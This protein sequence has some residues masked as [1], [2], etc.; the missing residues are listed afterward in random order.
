MIDDRHVKE[1]M[2]FSEAIQMIDFSTIPDA[3]VASVVA[4]V[5]NDISAAIYEAVLRLG[6]E[7]ASFDQNEFVTS[8][9]ESDV[10]YSLKT[11]LKSSIERLAWL[12]NWE[13]QNL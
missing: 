8:F 6:L 9:D 1:Q 13:S 5:K 2:G 7:P 3:E 12:E 4:R 10:E 11:A